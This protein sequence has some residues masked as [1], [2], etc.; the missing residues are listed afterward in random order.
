MR[1]HSLGGV[2]RSGISNCLPSRTYGAGRPHVG[3]CPKF[4]VYYYIPKSYGCHRLRI[5][6]LLFERSCNWEIA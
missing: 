2:A 6:D 5:P 4:L 3:L 1:L